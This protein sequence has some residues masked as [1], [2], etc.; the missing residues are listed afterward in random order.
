MLPRLWS[1][2]PGLLS[3]LGAPELVLGVRGRP[4]TP[5]TRSEGSVLCGANCKRT[6]A[7]AMMFT[8][9]LTDDFLA[10]FF[11]DVDG[12][13]AWP[14]ETGASKTL[15][16][17]DTTEEAVEGNETFAFKTD[18]KVAL[19]LANANTL[20]FIAI[21]ACSLDNCGRGPIDE[22]PMKAVLSDAGLGKAG[23]TEEATFASRSFSRPPLR[24]TR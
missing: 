10:G 12:V 20:S 22:E 13:S 4:L 16:P 7:L 11:S 15:L 19:S 14:G 24:G 23:G 1:K 18:L 8:S 5:L 17:S 9:P 6:R 21:G 2:Q 3:S